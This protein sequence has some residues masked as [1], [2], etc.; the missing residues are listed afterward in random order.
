MTISGN[1][2]KKLIVEDK[3]LE[4]KIQ[5]F[6]DDAE[7]R[8]RNGLF[9]TEDNEDMPI[10]GPIGECE[11]V[12]SRK[13]IANNNLSHYTGSRIVLT[14][15]NYGS[16]ATGFGGAGGHR[17]EAIDIVAGSLSCEEKN[18]KSSTKS[19]ANFATDGARIYLTERGDVSAYFGTQNSDKAISV[20]S[21]G[22][23][24]IGLKADHTLIIGREKVR[25]LAGLGHFEGGEMMTNGNKPVRTSI[26]IGTISETN[27]QPA[28]LGDNL[29]KYL[30]KIDEQIHELN[31]KIIS[32]EMDLSAYKTAMA[33]HI[34]PAAGVGAVITFPAPTAIFDSLK[35]IKRLLTKTPEII[36]DEYKRE[37]D[38]LSSLGTR[39]GTLKGSQEEYILSNTVFI[40]K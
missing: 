6:I 31:N 22:K 9:L 13:S 11:K 36:L 23:S 39:N 38:N 1:N 7:Y 28:V 21:Y 37:M 8:P 30:R 10:F 2:K 33:L 27:Y 12:F 15:D 19:R 4:D 17:C 32:L 29:V 34:H 40:G 5:D 14:K 35:G 16:R 24:G 26:E 18:V 20:S 3:V 25:I